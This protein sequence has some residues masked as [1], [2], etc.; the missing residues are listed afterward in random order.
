MRD[1]VMMEERMCQTI[2]KLYQFK[3]ICRLW[4]SIWNLILLVMTVALARM[5][6]M[7][8]NML[9]QG[10]VPLNGHQ[11]A[12]M[13]ASWWPNRSITQINNWIR[14]RNKWINQLGKSKEAVG[15][16]DRK[17]RSR[18]YKTKLNSKSLFKMPNSSKMD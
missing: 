4:E 2:I 13:A 1:R 11:C 18:R 17:R 9:R 3:T 12:L 8:L 7:I 14:W 5:I 15:C 6:S 10:A 16:R